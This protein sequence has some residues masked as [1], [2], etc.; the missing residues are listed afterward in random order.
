M[1]LNRAKLKY[2]TMK[3]KAYEKFIWITEF[4]AVYLLGLKGSI[5]VYPESAP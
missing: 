3:L 1:P 5:L 2:E 4:G